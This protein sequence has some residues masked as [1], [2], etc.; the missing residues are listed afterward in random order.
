MDVAARIVTVWTARYEVHL[1]VDGHGGDPALILGLDAVL[2][3]LLHAGAAHLVIDLHRLTGEDAAVLE[4]LAATCHRLWRRQGKLE[5]HGLRDRLATRPEVLAFPEV[6]GVV[7]RTGLGDR[8]AGPDLD[9]RDG[10]AARGRAQPV[11]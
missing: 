10:Q 4:L 7:S 9:C 5:V 2:E 8:A 11:S 1:T 3:G 6:F